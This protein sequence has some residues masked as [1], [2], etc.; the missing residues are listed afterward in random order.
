MTSCWEICDRHLLTIKRGRL[1][2]A[3]LLFSLKDIP[4]FLSF[5][6]LGMCFH[7]LKME[8]FNQWQKKNT[9]LISCRVV[10]ARGALYL[11]MKG[12]AVRSCV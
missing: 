10:F 4:K 8:H 2:F 1:L 3:G 6:Q 9:R 12:K 7:F 11:K 5:G